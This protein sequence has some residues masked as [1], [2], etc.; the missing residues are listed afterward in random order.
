MPQW[1]TGLR[2][3]QLDSGSVN[4][5]A[6]AVLASSDEGARKPRRTSLM[7]DWSPSEFS[8]WRLQLSED[9]VRADGVDHQVFLRYQVNLGAHGAHS[10]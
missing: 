2:F 10:F 4:F 1:R 7:F 9:R 5:G 3:D 6:N 8:R